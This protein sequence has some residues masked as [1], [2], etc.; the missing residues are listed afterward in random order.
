MVHF[1]RFRRRADQHCQGEHGLPQLLVE[2]RQ[3]GIEQ[4]DRGLLLRDV[5][6]GRRAGVLLGLQALEDLP[7]IRQILLRHR[8]PIAQR[9]CLEI[10]RRDAADHGESHRLPVV[11]AGGRCGARR[12]PQRPVPSPEVEFVARREQGIEVVVDARARARHRRPL[13]RRRG[14]QLDRRQQRRT[15]DPRLRVR[16]LDARDRSGKIVVAAFG[17]RDQLVE[18]G[19]SE[20]MPPIRRRPDGGRRLRPR[21]MPPGRRGDVRAPVRRADAAGGEQHAQQAGSG[22]FGSHEPP[23]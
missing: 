10:G 22:R 11:A 15:G 12:R 6:P 16:F 2:R 14:V 17:R 7:R 20:A 18:P 21:F 8:Y 3:R 5:E 1:E 9:K 19:R 23:D 13:A 4:R